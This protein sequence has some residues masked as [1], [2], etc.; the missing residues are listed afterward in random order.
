MDEEEEVNEI[1]FEEK[2]IRWLALANIHPPESLA[3]YVASKNA[4]VVVVT[5][6]HGV[7]GDVPGSAYLESMDDV[8]FWAFALAKSYLDDVGEWPLVGMHAE[9]ALL[10]YTEH[11]DPKRALTEIMAAIK[12]V[13]SDV[14]VVFIG[15]GKQ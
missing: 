3:T 8:P 11:K 2:R 1:S 10:D 4:S 14:E 7:E 9:Y 15:E 13:W 6:G 12:R 5:G